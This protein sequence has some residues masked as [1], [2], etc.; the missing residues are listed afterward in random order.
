MTVIAWDGKTLA[1]D[2]RAT[3]GGLA[4]TVTK[5]ERSGPSTLLGH[6]GDCATG[7]ELK[8]WWLAGAKPAD[9]PASARKDDSYATLIVITPGKI[10][11]YNTGPYP[12][13][14]EQTFAAWG[15]GRDFALAAMHLGK[16]A[17]EAVAVACVFQ[18]DCG[19]G[20][21]TLTLE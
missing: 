3:S 17:R 4:L 15:S 13:V 8:A 9:F 14:L 19:S 6:T 10:T 7:R 5:I 11:Y 21:D 16:D 2:K 12:L 1:A 18:T 20:I